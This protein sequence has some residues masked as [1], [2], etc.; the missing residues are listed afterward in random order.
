MSI[1]ID[2]SNSHFYSYLYKTKQS[3]PSIRAS[4]PHGRGN[5][6]YNRCLSEAILV[7]SKDA[8]R[9]LCVSDELLFFPEGTT[10]QQDTNEQYRGYIISEVAAPL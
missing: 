1:H 10:W 4:A 3:T 7:G 2:Q 5:S 9:A 8:P 6:S